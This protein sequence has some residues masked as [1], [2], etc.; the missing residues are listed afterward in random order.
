MYVNGNTLINCCCYWQACQFMTRKMYLKH[1]LKYSKRS[2]HVN[3][4]V[5]LIFFSLKNYD[6]TLFPCKL[7]PLYS[8][9]SS[10]ATFSLI[11]INSVMK[12]CRMIDDVIILDMTWEDILWQMLGCCGLTF[13]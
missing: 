3:D 11:S 2:S 7:S 5:M 4:S 12:S 1:E 9:P 8:S 6:R 10:L 13:F